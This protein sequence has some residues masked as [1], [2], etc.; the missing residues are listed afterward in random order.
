MADWT[1]ARVRIVDH[2]AELRTWL[3]DG[4]TDDDDVR[5]VVAMLSQAQQR[6]RAMDALLGARAETAALCQVAHERGCE[7]L[8]WGWVWQ[9]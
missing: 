4:F 3:I 9:A 5:L 8:R 1:Q 7:I 6:L 2:I